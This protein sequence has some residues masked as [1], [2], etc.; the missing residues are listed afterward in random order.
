[1]AHAVLTIGYQERSAI[2]FIRALRSARVA[3]LADIRAVPMSRRSDFRKAALA[4]LLDDAGI[5]Y[6]GIPQ[7]GTPKELRDRLKLDGDYGR[8]FRD[9]RAHMVTQRAA[10]RSLQLIAA[11]ER[12][13]LLCFER[14]A[15]TCH[16]SVVAAYVSGRLSCEIVDL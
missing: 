14:D 12:T 10:L 3:V 4:T 13:A 2:E 16:R 8:F 15:A 5:R 6:V 1:M 11:C 7:L 9:F